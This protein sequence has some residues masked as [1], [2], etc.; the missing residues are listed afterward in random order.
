MSGGGAADISPTF[1]GALWV[2]DFALRAAHLGIQRVYYHLGTIGNCAYCWWGPG[3]VASPYYGAYV[4]TAALAHGSY[5]SALDDGREPFAGYVI[6][7]A[8]RTPMRILL[9]N[10]E[11]Y[12]STGARPVQNFDLTGLSKFQKMVARRLTATSVLARQDQ[13]DN[14]VFGGQS[15][16]NTT[17]QPYG[18]AV[19]E[20]VRVV[21]GTAKVSLA[22]SEAL[23]I[24]LS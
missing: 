21:D 19:L 13:G 10:S 18:D 23:L 22:A 15:F 24:D 3:S 1:G 8:S 9:Y 12:D 16:A 5:I 4:A 20:A 2:M 14:P 6:Y 17:C 7:D 11:Y